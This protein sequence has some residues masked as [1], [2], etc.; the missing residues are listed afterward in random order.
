MLQLNSRCTKGFG[1]AKSST[2]LSLGCSAISFRK[3]APKPSLVKPG[4][5]TPAPVMDGTRAI[6]TGM[7]NCCLLAAKKPFKL[8]KAHQA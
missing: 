5:M 8:I 6:D 3:Q 1:Q 7:L 2:M 4:R